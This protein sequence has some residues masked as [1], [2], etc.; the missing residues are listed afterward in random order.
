L[1]G[2]GTR[3]YFCSADF[4]PFFGRSAAAQAKEHQPSK[5]GPNKSDRSPGGSRS[6][7]AKPARFGKKRA[8]RIPGGLPM[9]A[10]LFGLDDRQNTAAAPCPATRINLDS[11]IETTKSKDH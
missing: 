10:F 9:R 11:E 3:K 5:A 2:N 8:S 6:I 7:E 1:T 4:Q